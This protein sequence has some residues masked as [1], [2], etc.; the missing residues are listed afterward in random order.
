MLPALSCSLPSL[1]P[2]ASASCVASGNTRA[3]TLADTN[4]GQVSN[5]ATATG[6]APGA[7][8]DPSDT[9]THVVTTVDGL[10]TANGDGISVDEDGSVDINVLGNDNFGTDGPGTLA[11]LA[12]PANGSAVV[13]DKGTPGN[14]L[15]DPIL[16]T[17]NAGY[18]GPDSF[19]YRICDASTPPDCASATVNVTVG[20]V[21]DPPVAADDTASVPEDSV[22]AFIDV[23]AGDTDPDGDTLFVAAAS[24]NTA[25]NG[26]YSCTATGCTYTPPAN[27]SGPDSFTYSVCDAS[28]ACDTG[29]V[30]ITVTPVNDPPIAAP[31]S[32]SVAEDSN[33]NVIDV[34]GN[35][36]DVEGGTLTVTPASGTSAEGGSFECTA[37]G[38]TYT[39]P[40]G[41]VGTDTFTYQV[42]DESGAC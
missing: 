30:S 20:A 14:V 9:D 12:P 18:D 2:G 36:T 35:D 19:T 22:A 38:C 25:Q 10:P 1:A 33:G 13:D 31:D 28:N 11:V 32:P 21:N 17:P 6:D 27:Y 40:A 23:L 29:S 3:I 16:Y 34:L 4:A 37:S 41:F 26:T 7:L 39:P 5:T 8:A 15:D 42:C 24:G